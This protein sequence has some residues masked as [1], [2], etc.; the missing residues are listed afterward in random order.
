MCVHKPQ[1]RLV[2]GLGFSLRSARPVNCSLQ[3]HPALKL[4]LSRGTQHLPV[5][6]GQMLGGS[7]GTWLPPVSSGP[8]AGLQG[9]RQTPPCTLDHQ[10]GTNTDMTVCLNIHCAAL[11]VCIPFASQCRPQHST[12]NLE[13]LKPKFQLLWQGCVSVLILPHR[14]HIHLTFCCQSS[15]FLTKTKT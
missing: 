8:T 1:D 5:A 12:L 15:L 10:P 13:L 9:L 2:E 6:P 11:R 14:A 7:P 4:S 3:Q